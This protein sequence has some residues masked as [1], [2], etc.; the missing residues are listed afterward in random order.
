MEKERIGRR[1]FLKGMALGAGA[2]LGG[3]ALWTIGVA[4][5][6]T[7]LA[8]AELYR[9]VESQIDL[10]DP[11]SYYR[12]VRVGLFGRQAEVMPSLTEWGVRRI[13]KTLDGYADAIK[14]LFPEAPRTIQ[15]AR[16]LALEI[17]PYF[18]YED[19]RN[20]RRSMGGPPITEPL[21]EVYPS[22]QMAM[23]GGIRTF[24]VLGTADCED[25]EKSAVGINVRFYNPY[26]PWHEK[27]WLQVSTLVHELGHSQNV[28][29]TEGENME[30]ATQLATIEILAAMAT[31][32]N[33]WA[34]LPFLREVQGFAYDWLYLQHLEK[35]KDAG[36]DSFRKVIE[37]TADNYYDIAR[38]D[39][40]VS[41]WRSRREELV[42]LL[43]K[44]GSRP[45]IYLSE[46]LNTAPLYLTRPLPLLGRQGN[47]RLN[48]TAYVLKN[49]EK[50]VAD[51]PKLL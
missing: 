7:A 34:L 21:P 2:V 30:T 13:I 9:Q 1:E 46:A 45:H 47:L 43:G 37:E 32:G 4:A 17:V 25:P 20:T 14:P 15:E 3:E 31:H 8:S 6:T 41:F 33:K 12:N 28:S 38:F 35:R 16:A 42:G 10:N 22:L 48:D 50:M 24:H 51:Y 5:S 11:L 49:I 44:Y 18:I 40:S 27:G 29:C 26:S 36:F 19:M 39:K 23:M